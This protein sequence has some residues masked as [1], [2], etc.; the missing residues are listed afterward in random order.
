MGLEDSG[1]QAA[2]QQVL[3][4]HGGYNAV[5]EE[6]G[7]VFAKGKSAGLV[8]I[9][10]IKG[11]RPGGLERAIRLCIRIDLQKRLPGGPHLDPAQRLDSRFISNIRKITSSAPGSGETK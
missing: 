10:F 9:H 11:Y 1:E 5:L 6:E 2:V 3:H 7:H 4:F 8:N